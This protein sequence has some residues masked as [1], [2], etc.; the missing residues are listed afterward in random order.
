MN[1]LCAKCNKQVDEW[2]YYD[3]QENNQRVTTVKCHGEQETRKLG[4]YELG[5]DLLPDEILLLPM[6]AFNENQIKQIK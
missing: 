3:E 6:V 2:E 5:K 4:M 1:I